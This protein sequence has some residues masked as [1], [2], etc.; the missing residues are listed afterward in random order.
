MIKSPL[1]RLLLAIAGIAAVA[2]AS[3]QNFPSRPIQ[4]VVPYS[5][6]GPTDVVARLMSQRLAERLG[7][8]VVVQSMPGAGGSLGTAFVS[9]AKPDGY[10]LLFGVNSMAIFPFTRPAS[11]PLPF[12]PTEFAPVAGIAES[13][14]VIVASK[15]AGVHNIA[16]MVELAK[17]KED[18]LSFGSSGVGGTTHLPLALFAHRA[19]I[20]LLHVPYKGAAPAMVDTMSGV[21]SLSGPGY[22]S[23]VKDAIEA[24]SLVALAVTS[25][26]R[27]PFL[28]NV[29][30]WA[31]Q[32]YPDMVFP[33]WYGLFAPKGTPADIVARL[34]GELAKMAE[35]PGYQKQLASQGNVATYMTPEQLGTLLKDDIRKLGERLKAS[36]IS[37][38]E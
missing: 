7:S 9:R 32:G 16:E 30:T 6:G 24:G 38:Q 13:A 2:P 1:R 26:K 31:E 29:P 23:S 5:P 21:V 33:I 17:K 14:H 12:D 28:P 34:S 19:G 3:A 20:K 11:N 10:T 4:V 15:S 27:F 36:N 35:E 22:T 18:A 25:A 37:L 8:S